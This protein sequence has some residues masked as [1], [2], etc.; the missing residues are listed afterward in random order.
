[1]ANKIQLR[2]DTTANWNNVNPILA[3]GEPGLDITTNQV[4]YGDGA[5]AWVDLSYASGG[6]GVTFNAD[7]MLELSGNLWVGTLNDG[8]SVLWAPDT[9]EYVGLWYGGERD[10]EALN[11]YGPNVSITVGN[12][13]FDDPNVTV[14]W[15]DGPQVNID[16]DDKNW[17]FAADGILTLPFGSTIN[18]TPAA[19]GNGNGQ[20]VEIKPGGASHNNQLLRI[21]PTVVNPDGN[22]LHLTSGDLSVTDLFLGDDD[23]FVQIAADGKVCIGT[24]NASN[25][26]QFGTDGK[27][28]LPQYNTSIS[29]YD[30]ETT[31]AGGTDDIGLQVTVD[32]TIYLRVGDN[33]WAFGDGAGGANILQLP[34]GGEIHSSAGTGNVVVQSNDGSNNFNWDFN[35]HG[36]IALPALLSGAQGYGSLDANNNKIALTSGDTV[37]FGGFSGMILVNTHN[38]GG[39]SLYLCGGGTGDAVSIGDSKAGNS[40]GTMAFNSGIAGYTFTAD[41]TG[42]HVFCAIRTRTGG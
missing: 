27:I 37:N 2:R 7:G 36:S 41:E 6:G 20:A 25:I 12:E 34:A 13:A 15:P 1:M 32:K 31:F 14:N 28:T 26:W 4:K 10:P 33:Q 29:Q 21:Y 18:D 19:P 17:H 30:G 42:D 3:D 22:H 11:G 16:V 40:V 39:V 38:G 9:S 8:D 24:N 23:Q 5:N 35:T